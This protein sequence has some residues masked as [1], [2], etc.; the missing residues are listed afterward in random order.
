MMSMHRLI[1]GSCALIALL[2]RVEVA[3][4][5]DIPCPVQKAIWEVT[6]PLPDPW[7]GSLKEGQLLARESAFVN[8]R[9]WILCIYNKVSDS[10]VDESVFPTQEFVGGRSYVLEVTRPAPTNRDWST[11]DCPA[12]EL[13][14]GLK[15]AVPS[16]WTSTV[17]VFRF[18]E[19]V[20]YHATHS[21]RIACRYR[22]ERHD[23]WKAGP[24]AIMR[25]VKADTNPGFTGTPKPDPSRPSGLTSVFGVTAVTLATFGELRGSC[26][27]QVKFRGY[28]TAN[29]AGTVR[30]RVVHN[31]TAGHPKEMEFDR[32]EGRPVLFDIT[33][34]DGDPTGS[35]SARPKS[36]SRGSMTAAP[37]PENRRSGWAR[38][39]ILSPQSGVAR[40]DIVSYT[41]TCTPGQPDRLRK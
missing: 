32:P 18:Y 22:T 2:G 7:S 33:V 28:I 20:M 9:D 5:N 14:T 35:A 41:F 25:A 26:P 1:V 23:S 17:Y 40:S 15:T 38:L 39:E 31:N 3:A 10:S 19:K 29:G 27:A 36:A 11:I 13:T 12:T 6:T 37:A 4:A 34:G 30:Y 21:R 16:P 24:A 8:G